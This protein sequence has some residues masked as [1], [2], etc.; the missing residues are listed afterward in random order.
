MRHVPLHVFI[1]HVVP[2]LFDAQ[3]LLW[4]PPALL[5]KPLFMQKVRA[6]ENTQTAVNRSARRAIGDTLVQLEPVDI[7]TILVD[8]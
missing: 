4:P 1:V 6:L 3:I 7:A 2:I 5:C 8:I